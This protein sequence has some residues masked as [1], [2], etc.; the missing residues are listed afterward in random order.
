MIDAISWRMDSSAAFARICAAKR[1][2]VDDF[3]L[4]N[5]D[6]LKLNEPSTNEVINPAIIISI[7]VKPRRC[8][9]DLFIIIPPCNAIN[10]F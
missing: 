10:G 3:A 9:A 6:K 5:C 8:D 4:I 1:Y 2:F 7:R